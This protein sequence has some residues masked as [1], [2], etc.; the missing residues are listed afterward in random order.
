MLGEG[1]IDS[2]AAFVMRFIDSTSRYDYKR[3][4]SLQIPRVYFDYSGP[5]KLHLEVCKE[6]GDLIVDSPCFKNKSSRLLII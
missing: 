4:H 1:E 6:D 5:T 2:R 3:A